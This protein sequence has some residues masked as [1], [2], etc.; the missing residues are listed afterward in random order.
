MDLLHQ[1]VSPPRTEISAAE[2]TVLPEKDYV[3][4]KEEDSAAGGFVA[5]ETLASVALIVVEETSGKVAVP[6]NIDKL[7][8]H[9]SG[10]L[11][12]EESSGSKNLVESKI[13]AAAE[14][15]EKD[16]VAKKDMAAPRNNSSNFDVRNMR[17]FT[18][19]NCI[20]SSLSSPS[21]ILALLFSMFTVCNSSSCAGCEDLVGAKSGK[22]WEFQAGVDCAEFQ[23]HGACHEY[24]ADDNGEGAAN[25]KW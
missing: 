24:G 15:D 3:T 2:K 4:E 14:T 7:D 19:K 9:N 16:T 25:D 23:T 13:N 5:E 17:T 11:R 1:L 20:L 6:T 18:K 21:I 8:E 22:A 10:T 12:A